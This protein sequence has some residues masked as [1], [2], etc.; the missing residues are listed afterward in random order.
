MG[1]LAVGFRLDNNA[2]GAV[3]AGDGKRHRV[4]G[5]RTHHER[6]RCRPGIARS[7]CQLL[8]HRGCADRLARQ[9]RIRRVEAAADAGRGVWPTATAPS[10]LLLRS[11]TE[12]LRFLDA[13]HTGLGLW[14]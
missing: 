11:R 5:R 8:Q 9:R 4:C 1:A 2:R 3:Q 13:I 10:V 14:R 12:R 6:R 7:S